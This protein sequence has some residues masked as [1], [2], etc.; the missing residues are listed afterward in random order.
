MRVTHHGVAEDNVKAGDIRG[1]LGVEELGQGGLLVALNENLG[2]L[3][4]THAPSHGQPVQRVRWR[5]R[6]RRRRR[7]H[8]GGQPDA[9]RSALG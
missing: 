9:S 4:C 8:D 7:R 3:A 5:R 6:Q 1:Q 2:G